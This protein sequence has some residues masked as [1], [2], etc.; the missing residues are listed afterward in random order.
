MEFGWFGGPAKKPEERMGTVE[1][2]DMY[3]SRLGMGLEK[4]LKNSWIVGE[5]GVGRVQ[6]EIC[7]E[8]CASCRD[9]MR[10]YGGGGGWMR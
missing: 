4:G 2:Y 1:E 8:V 6:D 10:V 7:A 9:E 5:M 3:S